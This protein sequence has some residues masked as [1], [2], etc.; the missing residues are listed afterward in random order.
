MS[1]TNKEQVNVVN[2]EGHRILM[3][4]AQHDAINRF[5]DRF[6]GVTIYKDKKFMQLQLKIEFDVIRD[7]GLGIEWIALFDTVFED[8]IVGVPERDSEYGMYISLLGTKEQIKGAQFTLV[9]NEGK[10]A[11]FPKGRDIWQAE[12]GDSPSDA[13][14]KLK[15][16]PTGVVIIT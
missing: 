5:C 3:N 11:I 16:R 6:P 4:Q 14:E 15:N 9:E 1:T 2:E 8:V 13:L 10:F 12:V 7:M